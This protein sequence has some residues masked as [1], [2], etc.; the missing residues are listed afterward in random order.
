MQDQQ[1]RWETG[2]QNPARVT[3]DSQLNDAWRLISDACDQLRSVP[4]ST[5]AA[6]KLHTV[7]REIEK[8]RDEIR[9]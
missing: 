7:L 2:R 8:A 6:R 5:G 4:R 3:A 1:Q 9:P